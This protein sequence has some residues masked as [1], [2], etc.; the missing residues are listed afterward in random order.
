MPGEA[1]PARLLTLTG[2][3]GIGKTSLSLE[4]AQRLLPAFRDGAVFVPLASVSHPDGVV[5]A[6]MQVLGLPDAGIQAPLTRLAGSLRGRQMLLVLDNFEQVVTAGPQ[7]LDLLARCS[8]L[9]MI[10]TSREALRVRGERLFPVQTLALPDAAILRRDAYSND[11]ILGA[12]RDYP[13]IILFE[14]RAREA[15]PEFRLTAENANAV[16][17]ICATLDGLPLAIELVA[18]RLISYRRTNCCG[19]CKALRSPRHNLVACNLKTP[20]RARTKRCASRRAGNGTFPP[21]T[22]R[23]VMP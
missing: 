12:V 8:Q 5:P 18:A 11:L 1:T 16:A 21:G 20:R 15:S 10:V 6:I 13:A 14:Q 7:L 4:V 2:A 3:P 19:D 17:A 23:Y 9:Q 22:R